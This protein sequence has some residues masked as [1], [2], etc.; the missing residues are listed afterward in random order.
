M[1][2][3]EYKS[4]ALKEV[5]VDQRYFIDWLQSQGKEGWELIQILPS[6]NGGGAREFGDMYLA[7]NSRL[8]FKRLL[9]PDV[10]IRRDL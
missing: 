1:D 7:A 6:P 8:F 9:E 4:I 3:W 2:Q 5:P 10:T